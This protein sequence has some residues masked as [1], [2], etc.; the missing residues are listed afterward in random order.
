MKVVNM[1]GDIEMNSDQ[2]VING[3]TDVLILARVEPS[4]NMEISKV[5]DMMKDLSL[6]PTNYAELLDAHKKSIKN[7]LSVYRLIWVPLKKTG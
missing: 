7:Y 3:A 4:D 2:I 5:P 1:D 6:Y